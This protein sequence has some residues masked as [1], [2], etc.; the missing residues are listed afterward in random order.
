MN[1]S[2]YDAWRG[3][4]VTVT[5]RLDGWPARG[6]R[7][8]L[9]QEPEAPD[10]SEAPALGQWLWFAPMVPQS[11][12]DTDGHPKRGGF[13]PPVALPRRM[14]AGSDITFHRPLVVG[15]LVTKTM[16]IADIALKQGSTG[17]LV[18]VRVG[19]AYAEAEHGEP[20]LEETQTLVY[21][22]PPAPDEPAPKPRAAP[23]DA[24][25]SLEATVGAAMM[26]RYSA[27]TFNAH[28]IHYD[29]PYTVGAEGYPAILVQG[30]LGATLMLEALLRRTGGT[31][32][33]RFSFRGVQPIHVDEPLRVEGA[34]SA[35][36]WDL[37]IRDRSGALRMTAKA[38][39]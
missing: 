26:F 17:P 18:F 21:R 28:R 7:A 23:A 16:T 24:D 35:D 31:R 27:V 11:Q 37:W 33:K 15:S 14:W 20:L 19:N 29:T 12:I 25:W 2:D 5:E 4:T 38:E 36:G 39:G 34:Q 30:Q 9:D 3:R 1:I 13:L 22:D 10:G 8:L 6:L 32:P